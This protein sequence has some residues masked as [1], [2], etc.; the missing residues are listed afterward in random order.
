MN[1]LID[2]RCQKD[3]CQKEISYPDQRWVL[4]LRPLDRI[5]ATALTPA[6]FCLLFP[7]GI[8]VLAPGPDP[9]AAEVGRGG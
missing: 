2:T 8:F 6:A 3:N 9:V 4:S 1:K 7:C 5:E